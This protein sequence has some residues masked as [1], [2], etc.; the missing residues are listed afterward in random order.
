LHHSGGGGHGQR[1][2]ATCLTAGTRSQAGIDTMNHALTRLSIGLLLSVIAIAG[3]STSPAPS[4]IESLRHITV[5][6]GEFA[7]ERHIS[8]LAA[9][10]LSSGPFRHQRGDGILWRTTAPMASET[11]ITPEA[12]VITLDDTGA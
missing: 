12:G 6:E 8:V 1:R 2:N 9:P 5:P 11:R 10:L 4:P 7:Q 3:H